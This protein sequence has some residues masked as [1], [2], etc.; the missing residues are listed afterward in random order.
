MLRSRACEAAKRDPYW[1]N[2]DAEKFVAGHAGDDE[3][4]LLRFSYLPLP[5]VGHSHADGL[6]R[7]VLI[8]EPYGT[9]GTH[10]RWARSRLNHT[11]LTEEKTRK[12]RAVLSAIEDRDSVLDAYVGSANTWSSVTPVVLPGRD[13]H[14]H[15]K[16]EKLLIKAIVQA[17]IDFAAIADLRLQK[18]P[19]W[20]GSQHAWYYFAPKHLQN[21]PRWHVNLRFR[22]A[23]PGPLAIGAGRHCGLGLFA[24]QRE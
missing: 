2:E 10:S 23:I 13:D 8:A 9:V 14:K 6:I 11:A 22:E 19:F 17:G 15:D 20:R 12:P 5:S 3:Q 18:A 21:L 24:H 1:Q 7:R 16:A 4:S